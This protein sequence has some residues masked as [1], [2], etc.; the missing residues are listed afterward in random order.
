MLLCSALENKDRRI[1]LTPPS[2]LVCYAPEAENLLLETENCSAPDKTNF[3][4][5]LIHNL[6]LIEK[7]L[8]APVRLDDLEAPK[9]GLFAF[10]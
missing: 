5:P 4:S 1:Q 8:D 2:P 7:I 3:T 10:E 9:V 6:P